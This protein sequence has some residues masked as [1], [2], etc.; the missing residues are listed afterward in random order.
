[1]TWIILTTWCSWTCHR[2]LTC[3][4]EIVWPDDY[5][6]WHYSFRVLHVHYI[7]VI[8]YIHDLISH[9]LV[10]CYSRWYLTCQFVLPPDLLFIPSS[11]LLILPLLSHFHIIVSS[12]R[13]CTC[14]SSSDRPWF[15]S[16]RAWGDWRATV[17]RN[18][19]RLPGV[20]PVGPKAHHSSFDDD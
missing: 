11:A 18:P 10:L 7:H 8:V 16:I 6:I 9:D 14:W 15:F 2:F 1:M 5:D 3:D 4:L 12:S 19:G 13:V 17:R 20:S